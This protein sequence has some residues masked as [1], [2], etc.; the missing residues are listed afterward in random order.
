MT[1]GLKFRSFM[2]EGRG[3]CGGHHYVG[4]PFPAPN[5]T[6]KSSKGVQR[7]MTFSK[8]SNFGKVTGLRKG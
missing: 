2:A 1:E 6:P 4:T 3:F 7:L 8:V 5:G